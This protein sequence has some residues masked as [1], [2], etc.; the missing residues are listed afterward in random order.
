MFGAAWTLSVQGR[1]DQIQQY[2]QVQ[3][4]M[5]P[6]ARAW[7][8]SA[9]ASY[10]NTNVAGTRIY[11]ARAGLQR[12]RTA[13]FIDYS[14]SILGYADRLDQNSAGPTTSH[15]LVPAWSWTRRNI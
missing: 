8:N 14:Y 4:S 5:P 13:Q 10:T 1:L 3:R 11:S 12:T 9:L 6:G 2:G 7:T 15:A